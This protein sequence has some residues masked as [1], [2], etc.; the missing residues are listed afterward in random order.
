MQHKNVL[1]TKNTLNDRI[2]Q[3]ENEELHLMEDKT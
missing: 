1:Q 2:P 3:H